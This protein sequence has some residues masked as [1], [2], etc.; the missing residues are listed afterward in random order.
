MSELSGQTAKIALLKREE[1]KGDNIMA[2]TEKVSR[3]IS[4]PRQMLEEKIASHE[5]R[6]AMIGLGYVGFPVT[7]IDTS[8]RK[9]D[10]VESG[11]SDVQGVSEFEVAG[12]KAVGKLTATQECDV[13][14]ETAVV[15]CVPTFLNKTRDPDVSFI[16]KACSSVKDRLRCGQLVILE[17]TTY[18]STTHELVLPLL[19]ESGLKV[20]RDFFLIFSPE[21]VFM[22]MLEG[23]TWALIVW[24][25]DPN[26][27]YRLKR[28]KF[29]SKKPRPLDVVFW[30]MSGVLTEI[31]TAI[32]CSPYW[33]AHRSI[34]FCHRH[35][36]AVL[37]VM[38]G[39]F[40][41]LF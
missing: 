9:V 24:V 14:D 17:S 27:V 18:P 21:R 31:K 30:F 25:V 20:G 39:A 41:P 23:S 4:N 32:V 13:L 1:A 37:L 5:A 34:R 3:E 19:E 11:K 26:S 15:V 35:L 8:A 29:T 10:L 7:G 22:D 40:R 36:V 2:I 38:R 12:L 33:Y 6:I 16:L 28:V